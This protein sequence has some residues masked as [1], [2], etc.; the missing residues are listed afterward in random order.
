MLRACVM[1]VAGG[2]AQRRHSWLL[3]AAGRAPSP[4]FAAA[5]P[6]VG[7]PSPMIAGAVLA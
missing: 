5:S 2:H 1:Y 4:A 3:L 7:L 6:Y